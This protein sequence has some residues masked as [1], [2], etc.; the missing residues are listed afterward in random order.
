M[1]ESVELLKALETRL[2]DFRGLLLDNTPKARQALVK[3][4]R[5]PLWIEAT[6]DKGFVVE[7]ETLVGPLLLQLA[8][9]WRSL[10]ESNPCFRR[11]R[12]TS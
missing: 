9:S 11:E 1:I 7:G 2:G 12:P 3:L 4:L 10:G 6:D 8:K 5:G